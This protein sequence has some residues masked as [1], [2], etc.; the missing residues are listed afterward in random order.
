MLEMTLLAAVLVFA[1]R[2]R[3]DKVNTISEQVIFISLLSRMYMCRHIKEPNKLRACRCRTASHTALRSADAD[4]AL[5]FSKNATRSSQA[6]H[7]PS[8]PL[9]HTHHVSHNTQRPELRAL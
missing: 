3:E 2:G 9:R 4:G 8:I 1:W 7:K 5:R 6:Y